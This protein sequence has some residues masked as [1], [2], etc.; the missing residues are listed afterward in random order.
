[1][2]TRGEQEVLKIQRFLT[3]RRILKTIALICLIAVEMTDVAFSFDSVPAVIAVT[4]EPLLIYSAMI[5][6]ILGLRSLYFV[7]EALKAHL[8]NLGD[9]VGFLLLFV[10]GKLLLHA[11]A[12]ITVNIGLTLVVVVS[13]LVG[14]VLSSEVPGKK[15]R[16]R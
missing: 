4:R 7:M 2:I 14:G 8:S 12:G 16:A 11:F 1:M 3:Y 5:F 15:T 9:A 10:A 6:A 13:I